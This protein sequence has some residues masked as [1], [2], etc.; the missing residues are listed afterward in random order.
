[1]IDTSEGFSLMVSIVQ[2]Y[3]MKGFG[4]LGRRLSA[5]SSHG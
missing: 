3:H 5:D 2:S 4:R 1:V